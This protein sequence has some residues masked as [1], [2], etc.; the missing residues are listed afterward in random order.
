MLNGCADEGGRCVWLLPRKWCFR[1]CLDGPVRK[2]GFNVAT[3]IATLDPG[4]RVGLP[5]RNTQGGWIIGEMLEVRNS[6]GEVDLQAAALAQLDQETFDE[7]VWKNLAPKN[8]DPRIWE[9]LVSAATVRRTHA[10]LVAGLHRNA[11]LMKRRSRE[12]DVDLEQARRRGDAAAL[13]KIRDGYEEWRQ[14]A[15]SF[16]WLVQQVISEVNEARQRIGVEADRRSA[17]RHREKLRLL[18]GAVAEHQRASLAAGLVAEPHDMALWAVLD[19]LNVPHGADG[20]VTLRSLATG[21]SRQHNDVNT[22]Q[23]V[24]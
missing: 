23:K 9:A 14:G 3:N 19:S 16:R 22:E 10:T 20:V 11:D 4:Q 17:I 5:D 24:G 12:Y 2:A 7:A 15:T 18:A 21:Q 6:T 1:T 8:R 13:E